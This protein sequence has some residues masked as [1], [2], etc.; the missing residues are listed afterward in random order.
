MQQQHIKKERRFYSNPAHEKISRHQDSEEAVNYFTHL[1]DRAS[2]L[3]K[4]LSLAA[5]MLKSNSM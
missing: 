5:L 3:P 4:A 1:T 2:S